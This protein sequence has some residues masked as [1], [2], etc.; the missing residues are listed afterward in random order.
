M[1][2]SP[3]PLHSTDRDSPVPIFVAATFARGTAA[4]LGSVTVLTIVP[5]VTCARR[6]QG[7]K[8]TRQIQTKG[9][10]F[11]RIL[12]KLRTILWYAIS[13]EKSRIKKTRL[14]PSCCCLGP[15]DRPCHITSGQSDSFLLESQFRGERISRCN[16]RAGKAFGF[17]P[18]DAKCGPR[19]A[20]GPDW[21]AGKIAHHA[22]HAA[23][24]FFNFFVVHSIAAVADGR[25]LCLEV[26]ITGDGVRGHGFEPTLTNN[27]FH[28]RLRQIG[29]NGLSH[30]GAIHWVAAPHA[31]GHPNRSRRFNL[32]Q[33]ENVSIIENSQ[34]HRL[35][36]F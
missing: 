20:D 5:V 29:Q 22:A 17:F 27:R 36:G 10:S 1:R 9:L 28:L 11:I 33:V 25:Q 23:H 15:D 3:S 2:Y 24:T 35:A 21:P 14:G 19:D 26:E 8:T 6:A 30:C 34:V 32:V 12:P 13:Y 31:G 16:H 7:N 18:A 4:P